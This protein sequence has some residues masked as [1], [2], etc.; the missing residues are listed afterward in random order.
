MLTVVVFGGCGRLGRALQ[1]S[2]RHRVVASACDDCDITDG[3]AIRSVLQR[4]TPDAAIN[5]AAVTSAAECEADPA[6]ALSVNVG[7]ALAFAEACREQGVYAVQISSDA[8]LDPVNEY[9]RSKK[10]AESSGADAHLRTNFYGADHWLVRELTA[11]RS[12]RLLANNA[13]NPIS[14]TGLVGAL[15]RAIA[16]RFRGVLEVGTSRPVSYYAFGIVMAR[17]LGANERLLE[18]TSQLNGTVAFPARTYLSDAFRWSGEPAPDL[19]VDMDEFF[20]SRS[21]GGIC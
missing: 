8:V 4:L 19:E 11:C 15:D 16:G 9:A 17:I 20:S 13:F 18:P 12:A 3:G 14:A 21:G 10:A 2:S 5:C 7:G 1:A 6:R